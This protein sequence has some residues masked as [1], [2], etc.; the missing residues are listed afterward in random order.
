MDPPPKDATSRGGEE[1]KMLKECLLGP[2][3]DLQIGGE[4]ITEEQSLAIREG[5]INEIPAAGFLEIWKEGLRYVQKYEF[6]LKP[7]DQLLVK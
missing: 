6:E 3:E 5:L 7:G 4:G 1:T 2:L